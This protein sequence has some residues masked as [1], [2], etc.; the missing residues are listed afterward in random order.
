MTAEQRVILLLRTYYEAREGWDSRSSGGGVRLM[1]SAWHE[2]SY[3]ELERCL[4]DL[5]DGENRPLWFHTTRRYR[6]GEH[7]SLQV[8]VHRTRLGPSFV[9][10]ACCELEAGASNVTD[11]YASVKVY[12]WRSDVRDGLAE[13]GVQHL[14]A[15]M[16]Q[17]R[18]WRITVPDV[19]YRRAV[20]LP[21]RDEIAA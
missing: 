16:F 10:P 18:H 17:G 12:R 14:T 11:R 19:F 3:V 5:R 7:V 4:A 21:L 1:P 13:A 8:P 9:L 6:D 20:G 15:S 2:G